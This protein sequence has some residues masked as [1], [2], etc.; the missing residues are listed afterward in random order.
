MKPYSSIR[1]RILYIK[2]KLD[3][4]KY[5]YLHN[6]FMIIRGIFYIPKSIIYNDALLQYGIKNSI[7]KGYKKT[8]ILF[9]Q[10]TTSQASYYYANKNFK[11]CALN[12]TNSNKCAKG[13]YSGF[14]NSEEELCRTCPVLYN[15]LLNTKAY[16]FE[17]SSTI[18]YTPN[19]LLCRNSENYY[20]FYKKHI[21][22]N[23]VSGS[24]PNLNIE[25]FNKQKVFDNIQKIF[26]IPAIHG[27]DTLILG[28][29]GCDMFRNNPKIIAELFCMLISKYKKLYK[30]ICFAIPKGYNY[31]IFKQVFRKYNLI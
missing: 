20:R 11:V 17:W 15:S 24:L 26:I 30:I 8:E 7:L 28:A 9:H 3:A 1:F 22:L 31:K 14:I 19:V 27:N 16:P 5:V 29:W 21:S 4:Y 12:F 2:N 10:T 18:I 23:V 13:Y 25:K 6:S